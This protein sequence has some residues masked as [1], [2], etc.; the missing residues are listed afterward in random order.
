MASHH[1]VP[2]RVHVDLL[3]VETHGHTQ[4]K[5]WVGGVI[6][7]AVMEVPMP[8]GV[9]C[10][11]GCAESQEMR[12]AW[13]IQHMCASAAGVSA[14]HDHRASH[15]G[16]MPGDT[17]D[18]R[19]AAHPYVVAHVGNTRTSPHYSKCKTCTHTLRTCHG[20]GA[21]SAYADMHLLPANKLHLL[22]V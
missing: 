1:G 14:S 17:Y 10:H 5:S 7:S 16:R 22:F 4:N 18:R 2:A 15:G 21:D 12:T 6:F 11:G 20:A 19:V 13:H 9:Q 8:N 3:S